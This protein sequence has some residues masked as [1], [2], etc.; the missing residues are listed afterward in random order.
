MALE[1]D[2]NDHDGSTRDALDGWQREEILVDLDPNLDLEFL[3][4]AEALSGKLPPL[5]TSRA[6]LMK[7]HNSYV[8]KQ[9]AMQGVPRLVKKLILALAYPPSVES[10]RELE[11]VGS[12]VRNS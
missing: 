10:I 8:K 11:P 2:T 1:T 7:T 3:K 5:R 4:R 6:K 12:P 9:K